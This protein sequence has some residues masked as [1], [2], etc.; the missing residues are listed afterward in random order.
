MSRASS[1]IGRLPVVCL[2][3]LYHPIPDRPAGEL[4]RS[5]DGAGCKAAA[6]ASSGRHPTKRSRS[7]LRFSFAHGAHRLRGRAGRPAT[8]YRP[9]IHVSLMR[10]LLWSAAPTARSAAFRR[11]SSEALAAPGLSLCHPSRAPVPVL[12]GCGG[13]ASGVCAVAPLARLAVSF[14]RACGP[15]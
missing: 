8:G 14:P 2:G 4:V 9:V 5:C 6:G 13:R 7:G 1:P 10:G 11:T 12:A 3:D 15:P